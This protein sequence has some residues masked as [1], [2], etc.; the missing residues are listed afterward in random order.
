MHG[1][2]R[3][4][5][6]WGLWNPTLWANQ[7]A[8]TDITEGDNGFYRAASGPDACTGLGAT[9]GNRVARLFNEP[10]RPTAAV[11]ASAPSGASSADAGLRSGQAAAK[12]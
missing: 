2:R 7:T 12:G 3:A 11:A 8:F 10:E 1:K 4:D 6:S 9:I 5:P